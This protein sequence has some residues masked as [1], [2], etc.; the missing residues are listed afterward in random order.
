MHERQAL[1]HVR[2][3]DGVRHRVANAV[4]REHSSLNR[5]TREDGVG[6]Q[7]QNELRDEWHYKHCCR[8]GATR[9]RA[10]QGRRYRRI[11]KGYAVHDWD[12]DQFVAWVNT[13]ATD[14]RN[15]ARPTPPRVFSTL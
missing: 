14:W 7:S 6:T 10:M 15:Y 9:V 11:P 8:T 4:E 12:P 5:V 3:D 1:A 13:A 2:P